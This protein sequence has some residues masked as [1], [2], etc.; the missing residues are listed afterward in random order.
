MPLTSGLWVSKLT[1]NYIIV[2]FLFYSAINMGTEMLELDVRLT[3]DKQVNK[4][5]RFKGR[6]SPF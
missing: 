5:A 6:L 3:A 1:D 2:Y 4:Q